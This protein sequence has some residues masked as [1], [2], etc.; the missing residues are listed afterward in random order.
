M[1]RDTAHQTADGQ[2]A[3]HRA[4]HLWWRRVALINIGVVVLLSLALVSLAL[5][6]RPVDR[7]FAASPDGRIIELVPLDA[8]IM[9]EQALRNWIVTAV[10]EAFTMGHHDWQLR[11]T[12]VREFFTD[13]GHEHL[14]ESL[15][16]SLFLQQLKDNRQVSS[17]V[18]RGAP[19]IVDR[20]TWQGRDAIAL[21]LPMLLTFD[22]GNRTQSEQVMARVLVVRVAIEER[23]AGIAIQQLIIEKSGGV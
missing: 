8:P 15:Q 3:L 22:V 17:A 21:Q 14:L 6:S 11:L 20:F 9:N 1:N 19:V 18:A 13:E 23:Q 4:A 2:F 10:T 12:Q 5:K 7:A 16:T